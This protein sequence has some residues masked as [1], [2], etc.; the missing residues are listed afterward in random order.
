MEIAS[1]TV[2]QET[3]ATLKRQLRHFGSGHSRPTGLFTIGQYPDLIGKPIKTLIVRQDRHSAISIDQPERFAHV[4]LN[5]P[6][7]P[8]YITGQFHAG[9]SRPTPTLAVTIN[10]TIQAVSQPWIPL[11]EKDRGQWS[12]LVPEEAFQQGH[13]EVE[14]FVISQMEDQITLLRPMAIF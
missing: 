4:D 13:N 8:A 3:R 14:V 7:I 12:A 10:G 9:A 11:A 1:E 2:R 6:F 5:A